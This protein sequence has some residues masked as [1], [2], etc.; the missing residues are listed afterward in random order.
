MER[1]LELKQGGSKD[2]LLMHANAYTPGCYRQMC[3][4]LD[5]DVHIT[6]PYQ[7]Q[8]WQH[9][10]PKD[11]KSWDELADDIINYLDA[12]LSK[13]VIGIGHSMG[14]VALWYA[15]T[16][17]PQ[18]FEKLILIE[19]V[20]L[21]LKAV[22]FSGMLPYSLSKRFLPIIKIALNRRDRWNSRSELD[23]YLASKKVFQRFDKYVL[24]D[25]KE[26]GFIEE[27]GHIILRYPKAWE[28][29][30]YGSAPNLWGMMKKTPCPMT[31]LRAQYSDV[32]SAESWEKIKKRMS[33]AKH[34]ELQGMGHLAPFEK[35]E[36]VAGIISDLLE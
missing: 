9:S 4:Y 23:S 21:P 11:F 28:A 31:V 6:A 22:F 27:G 1:V 34:I 26:D 12:H 17:Q 13:P 15:A 19:P 36:E 30:I 16:K 32:M 8:L 35:P 5:G 33:S 10:D 3:S 24:D 20:I 2:V 7:R 14:S 18:Y 29:R 25:Y